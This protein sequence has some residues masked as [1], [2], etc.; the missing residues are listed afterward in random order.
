MR[1]FF[2]PEVVQT[3]NMDCGPAALACL[4]SGFGIRASYGRLREACQTEVDGTSIDVLETV[5]N[6]MSL[7]AEQIMLPVDHLLLPESAALPAI[8]VV[9]QAIGTT[10]FVVAWRRHGPFAAVDR[11]VIR[12]A[13]TAVV[14]IERNM[15]YSPFHRDRRDGRRARDTIA[16]TY[17][18]SPRPVT[19]LTVRQSELCVV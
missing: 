5:A 3:S 7:A 12:K 18:P 6:Q 13:A 14:R 11:P 16:T 15:I 17:L 2:V 1:R 9:R 19:I 8:V 10:H 4:L